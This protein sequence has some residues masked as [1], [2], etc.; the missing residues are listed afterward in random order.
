[1]I[2][3][4]ILQL[5]S[6][7]LNIEAD[8]SRLQKRKIP[9]FSS[10]TLLGKWHFYRWGCLHKKKLDHFQK[11]ALFLFGFILLLSQRTSNSFIRYSSAAEYG[12]YIAG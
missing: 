7:K 8:V 11:H 5:L 2:A 12:T 10:K 4:N 1:L 9:S 3:L 6:Q